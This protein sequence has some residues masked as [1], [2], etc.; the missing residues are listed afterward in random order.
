MLAI[1]LAVIIAFPYGLRAVRKRMGQS[2][3]PE[4]PS[5][6]QQ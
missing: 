6:P 4:A 3:E 1:S 5:P 2:K